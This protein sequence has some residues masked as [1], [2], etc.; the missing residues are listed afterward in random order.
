[1]IAVAERVFWTLPMALAWVASGQMEPVE[2]SSE[3][4]TFAS[5]RMQISNDDALRL[6]LENFATG[7]LA[8]TALSHVD[9]QAVTVPPSEWAYLEIWDDENE[10]VLGKTVG[11]FGPELAYRS[12]MVKRE[13]V[14]K[15]WP[16]HRPKQTTRQEA[17]CKRWLAAIIGRSP[18]KMTMSKVKFMASEQAEGMANR[19]LERV[20]DECVADFPEWHRVG[21][22]P[23]IRTI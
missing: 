20:W 2:C 17:E 13:T 9:R 18:N 15:L 16:P 1:M 3:R 14:L 23:K 21:R 12:P 11:K 19:A 22:P 4:S 8:V 5:V 6:L 7:E 10:V